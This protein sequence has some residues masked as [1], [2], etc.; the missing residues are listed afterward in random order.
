MEQYS[1]AVP[2]LLSLGD[3]DKDPKECYILGSI[4]QL[5][6]STNGLDRK[7][8]GHTCLPPLGLEK[9]DVD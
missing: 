8:T 2:V 9:L 4:T 3:K 5:Q 6:P 7:D 1:V